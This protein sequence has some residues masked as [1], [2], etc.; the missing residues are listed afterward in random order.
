MNYFKAI[1][2]CILPSLGNAFECNVRYSDAIINNLGE[3]IGKWRND[4]AGKNVN[5]RVTGMYLARVEKF[6]ESANEPW[7]D[8][9]SAVRLLWATADNYISQNDCRFSCDFD[10]IIYSRENDL[11]RS[12]NQA[13]RYSFKQHDSIYNFINDALIL[14]RYAPAPSRGL[15]TNTTNYDETAYFSRVIKNGLKIIKTNLQ[16]TEIFNSLSFRYIVEECLENYGD[17]GQI[18]QTG[19]AEIK[20]NICQPPIRFTNLIMTEIPMPSTFCYT[21]NIRPQTKKLIH[22]I[23]SR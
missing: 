23:F 21:Y 20:N 14:Y 12:L 15:E 10:E 1:L 18:L 11:R 17:I 4:L 7:R 9:D 22:K 3:A 16:T 2:F 8:F 13:T 5:F 19:I 6:V